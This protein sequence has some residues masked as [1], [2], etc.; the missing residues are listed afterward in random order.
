MP[1]SNVLLDFNGFPEIPGPIR[2]ELAAWV[3]DGVW[4]SDLLVAILLNDLAATI[5]IA[6]PK[7]LKFLKALCIFMCNHV[8]PDAWGSHEK[9]KNWAVARWEN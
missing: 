4:P 5:A 2:L 6:K 7:D 1:S 3:Q 8:P 9:L